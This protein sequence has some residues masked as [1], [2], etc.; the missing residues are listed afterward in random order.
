MSIAIKQ[1]N[2]VNKIAKLLFKDGSGQTAALAKLLYKDASGVV[3][4]LWRKFTLPTYIGQYSL[5]VDATAG[6]I[7]L[8]SC[9]TLSL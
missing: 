8:Y 5:F 2:Q 1:D 3:S 9:G 4:E 6:R 7:E